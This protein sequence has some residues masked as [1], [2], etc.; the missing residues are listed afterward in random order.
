MNKLLKKTLVFII[1]VAM[2]FTTS[3]VSFATVMDTDSNYDGQ[4]V[5]VSD[6]QVLESEQP[7]EQTL[8]Q[9]ESEVQAFGTEQ[10]E[11]QV[12]ESGEPKVQAFAADTDVAFQVTAGSETVDITVGDMKAAGAT[13]VTEDAP[14][15]FN[16]TSKCFGTFY[17]LKP[18]LTSKGIATED[19]TGISA[20]ASDGFISSYE[21][22]D[23]DNIYVFDMSEVSRNGSYGAEGTYGAGLY[24][25]DGSAAGSTWPTKI[26]N[27]TM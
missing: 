22:S 16:S 13:E 12:P 14:W 20:F 18:I 21:D 17:Q 9:E 1:S 15:Y 6:E 8:E 10:P 19:I 11:E 4:E 7:E 23:V 26:V 5:T 24:T 2:I 3:A 27:I 25:E